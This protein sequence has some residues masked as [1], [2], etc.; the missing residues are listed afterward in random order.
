LTRALAAEWA[1]EG[2]RVN[3]VAPSLI[4]TD[5][6]SHLKDRV[7][8]FE[9]SRTPLRRLATPDDV[10]A[11]VSYFAGKDAAFVTGVVL[12]VSGGQVMK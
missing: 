7:F 12:T 2:V 8:K 10:A 4:E 3:G 1:G 11:T 9:A 5:M 6:T